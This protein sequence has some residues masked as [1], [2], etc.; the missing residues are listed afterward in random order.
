M[1]HLSRRTLD[2][3]APAVARPPAAALEAKV[4]IVHLGLG[5]FHRAH[6]AILTQRALAVTPGPWAISGASLR[7]PVVRDILRP[8]DCL[9][10]L[11]E[12]EGVEE[13]SS[14]IGVLREA[15]FAPREAEAL[16]DRLAASTTRIVTLTVTEK[17]YCYH[18][19]TGELDLAHPDIRADLARASRTPPRS[20]LGWLVRGLA[21]RRSA[22]AGGLTVLCCDNMA[23]NGETLRG[24]VRQFAGH[25]DPGLATWI[26][27]EVRF[28]SSMVDRIV[29][30]AT[31][32]SLDHA[33]GVLGLRDEAAV[34]AEA[35][36]QW[37]I[38]DDFAAG[39]PHWEAVGVELVRDV[40]PYQELKLRLLNGAHSAIAY[41]GALLG[42]PF[43]ADVMADPALAR[44]VERLMLEDIAPLT[45]APPGFD[46]EGYVQALLQRFA[47]RTLRHR[48][49]QIAMDGSQKIPVRWLPVLREARRRGSPAPRLVTALAVWLRFLAGRDEAGRELPLDDPLAPRLRA[50]AAAAG[51]DPAALVRALLEIEEVFGPDLCQDAGLVDQLTQAFARMARRGVR[52]ALAD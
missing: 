22:G 24:L 19:A 14:V 47:N 18:P 50:T 45:P 16:L 44:F 41:L 3:V 8:Q 11:I 39:R 17:G 27:D 1:D 28:P 5:A 49:L 38:E 43:V 37:V 13:M 29:P 40:R 21:Q 6:Q 26:E 36:V 25:I 34:S 52:A 33:A 48:T 32:A 35:F 23:S 51:H 12:S 10:V 30:A 46:V 20:T 9:Y 15:L 4:G 7:S 42:K 31:P 2:A